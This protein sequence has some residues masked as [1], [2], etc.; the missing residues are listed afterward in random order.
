MLAFRRLASRQFASFDYDVAVIGAGPGGYVSAIKSAQLGMKT[1]CIEKRATL[2]GTC[3][4]VGC[5][6]AKALLNSSHKYY[7]AKHSYKDHGVLMDNLRADVPQMMKGKDKAVGALTKGVESL[8][9]KNSVTWV[10]GTAEFKDPNTLTIDGKSTL[11]ARKFVI[12]TGSEPS[13]L[14]GGILPIDEKRIL[15]STG[16]MALQAAPKRLV[17]IGGGVIGLELGSVWARLGTEVH[18]VEF[19]PRIAPGSDLEIAN[20]LQKLLAK[21]GILF[22]LGAKVTG[23]KTSDNGVK[24][25][26]EKASADAKDVPSSL[27]ADYVLVAVGRRAYT[28]G[29][30]LD[31]ID[32]TTDKQ[33]K[34]NVG[35]NLQTPKHAHIYAIGDCVKGPMLAHKAEEE[36]IYVAERMASRPGHMNYAAIPSVIYTHPELAGVGQTEEELKAQSV[37]Y[38][39]GTFPFLANSRAKANSVISK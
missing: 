34:V 16:A 38:N 21:Q 2:G 25:E 35:F 14:P 20:T 39:K 37:P 19:L 36:G 4:N 32:I 33:G 15:S 17:V 11:T 26:I 10:K 3:L 12:A 1:A 13:N 24:V 22:H 7:E 31:R 27:E 30:G 23:G 29:L 18:V 6:P 28:A 9:K 8:F 5:I